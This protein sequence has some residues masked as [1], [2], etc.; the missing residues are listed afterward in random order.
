MGFASHRWRARGPTFREAPQTI[1]AA[2]AALLVCGRCGQVVGCLRAR[3]KRVEP[4]RRGSMG[5]FRLPY[6]ATLA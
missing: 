6:L 5:L 4:R 1:R 2:R 3:S